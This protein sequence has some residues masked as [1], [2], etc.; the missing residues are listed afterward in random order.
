MVVIITYFDHMVYFDC[1]TLHLLA[2]GCFVLLLFAFDVF[3][4]TLFS[5]FSLRELVFFVDAFEGLLYSSIEFLSFHSLF[6][7]SLNSTI[8]IRYNHKLYQRGTY[9]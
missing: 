8:H 7:L 1:R 9:L 3:C 2:P 6:T 5:C 4:R